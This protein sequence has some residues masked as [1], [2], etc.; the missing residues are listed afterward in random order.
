MFSNAQNM[1]FEYR[2]HFLR[3]C[4]SD[5]PRRLQCCI[6]MSKAIYR[7]TQC[8]PKIFKFWGSAIEHGSGDK[9][10]IAEFNMHFISL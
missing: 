2:I 10:S 4:L 8:L 7:L 5:K 9:M 6:C 1:N 3:V